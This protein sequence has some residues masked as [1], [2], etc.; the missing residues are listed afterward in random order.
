MIKGE[1]KRIEACFTVNSLRGY[2]NTSK[3]R[4]AQEEHQEQWNCGIVL[5]A[6]WFSSFK[7]SNN[8]NA[9]QSK[10]LKQGRK[11]WFKNVSQAD[12]FPGR[13]VIVKR[14]PKRE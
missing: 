3:D 8:D 2:T 5:H 10:R 1:L 9:K 12:Y 4:A 6:K 11:N 7:M 13:E 14:H